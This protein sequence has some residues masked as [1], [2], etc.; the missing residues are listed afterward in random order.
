MTGAASSNS[1]VE[2]EQ[3]RAIAET[4]AA[5]IIAKR[6]PRDQVECLDNIITACTR[7]KLAESAA[8]Q[9]AK[10]GNDIEGPTI[11]LAEAIAQNWTNIQFGVR[12]LERQRG[13]SVAEA[14]AWDIQNNV[15]CVKTFQVPHVRH[16]KTGSY[17]LKDPRDIYEM[18]ANNGAR[19]C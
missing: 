14:Y 5:M 15:R 16:T 17:P 13:Y 11:R 7:P 1:V 6:F 3:Q 2:I 8:Y 18:V 12:E 10:G 4:Q 9:Y 19:R